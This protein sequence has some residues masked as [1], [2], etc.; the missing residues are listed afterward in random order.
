MESGEKFDIGYFAIDGKGGQEGR[1]RALAAKQLGCNEI[2][3]V[4]VD[5][6]IEYEDIV[7]FVSTYKDMDRAEVNNA[8]IL[9]N[10]DGISDLC[11]RE[12]NHFIEYKLAETVNEHKSNRVFNKLFEDKYFGK[13]N[14][15]VNSKDIK[16]YIKLAKDSGFDDDSMASQHVNKIISI[17]ERVPENVILYRVIFVDDPKQINSQDI[18]NH[19][20]AKERDLSNS[21]YVQSH[22]GG[23]T[24]YM[25][26]V[27]APK[28]LID[29]H[30][31]IV[32][33]IK[34]PHEKEITLKNKGLGAEIL[35]VT[36]FKPQS[37][38]DDFLFMDY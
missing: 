32:N 16:K 25:L 3:V 26:K 12:L 5:K 6:T 1:H 19:Y 31:T 8:F 22:V 36:P 17:I 18:G 28:N 35:K 37:S 11:W 2:P 7:E 13:I 34:Y 38:D 23:G 20:V 9:Q 15:A 10:Y 33:N 21:H 27:R 24:P 29:V 14:E 30:E 4:V